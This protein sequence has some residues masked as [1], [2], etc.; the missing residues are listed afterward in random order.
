M[1]FKRK[2]KPRIALTKL[3]VE[4]KYKYKFLEKF[5]FL[6]VLFLSPADLMEFS[7]QSY[8]RPVHVEIWSRKICLDIGLR[9]PEKVALEKMALKEGRILVLASGGGRE[10]LSLSQ[11]GFDVTLVDFVPKMIERAMDNARKSGLRISGLV[12]DMSRL[13]VSEGAYDMVWLFE[14]MYSSVPTRK[15]RIEMLKRI[16]RA[17]K[18]GGFFVCQFLWKTENRDALGVYFLKK[19][20]AYLTLGNFLYENGDV[21][22]KETEFQHLFSSEEEIRAEFEKGG[23]GVDYIHVP[24]NGLRGEALLRRIN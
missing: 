9:D 17:I 18:P 20:F 24:S 10:A 16:R 3:L 14:G 8:T 22:W 7:R 23:F 4:L 5:L 2:T 1:K 11:L 6:P 13:D 21:L 19:L 15:R 12:Q